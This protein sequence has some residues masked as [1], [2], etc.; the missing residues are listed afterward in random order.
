MTPMHR[1]FTAVLAL[2]LLGALLIEVLNPH[3]FLDAP[4]AWVR[5][6]VLAVLLAGFGFYCRK[7]GLR[8]INPASAF[9]AFGILAYIGYA[10]TSHCSAFAYRHGVSGAAYSCP[11][12][13]FGYGVKQ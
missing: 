11:A 6:A 13:L 5:V 8:L 3:S 12:M 7:K 9:L 4:G 10:V 2:V 1:V